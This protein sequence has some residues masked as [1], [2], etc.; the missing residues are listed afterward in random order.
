MKIMKIAKSEMKENN[1][2]S[3]EKWANKNEIR[4]NNKRR[5]WRI[6]LLAGDMSVL[7]YES[8]AMKE[9]WRWKKK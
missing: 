8:I 2:Y 6:A 1:Q 5:K 4:N 3:A 9:I 7:K